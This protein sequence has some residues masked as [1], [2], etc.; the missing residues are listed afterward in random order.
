M[1]CRLR[2]GHDKQARAAL[3][4]CM[5]TKDDARRIALKDRNYTTRSI[6]QKM[7]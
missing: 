1:F 3:K 7:K 4:A 6:F 2:L 5:L